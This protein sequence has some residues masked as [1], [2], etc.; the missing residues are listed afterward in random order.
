MP[1]AAKPAMTLKAGSSGASMVVK[2]IETHSLDAFCN[3]AAT[4]QQRREFS[5]WIHI[6][7]LRQ[8]FLTV[9]S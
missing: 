8:A 3:Q 1:L 6:L 4:P 2:L 7:V 5:Q 9:I